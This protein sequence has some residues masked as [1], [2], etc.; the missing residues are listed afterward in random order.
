VCYAVI[1]SLFNVLTRKCLRCFYY[2]LLLSK[3]SRHTKITLFSTK[4]SFQRI[5]YTETF[6]VNSVVLLSLIAKSLKRCFLRK[7]CYFSMLN[8]FG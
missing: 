7:K 4:A 3:L 2:P 1:E 8:S 6:F 5:N